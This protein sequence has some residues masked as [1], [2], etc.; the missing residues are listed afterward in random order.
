MHG[1]EVLFL[2]EPFTGL[3]EA[4]SSRLVALLRRLHADGC[5]IV[6]TVHEAARAAEGPTR[7][8]VI[9]EG[10]IAVDEPIEASPRPPPS[11]PS[12]TRSSVPAPAPVASPAARRTSST[13]PPTTSRPSGCSAA[14]PS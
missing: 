2:D 13:S 8:V 12:S 1:P 9:G 6:M 5:T 10:G 14:P 7:L 4:S 3:D 11:P